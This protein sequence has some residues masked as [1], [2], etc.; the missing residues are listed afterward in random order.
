MKI[1]YI[2]FTD[3]QVRFGSASDKQIL[4]QPHEINIASLQDEEIAVALKSYFNENKNSYQ[5]LVLVLSRSLVH[6]K[7]LALPANDEFEVRQMVGYELATLL[8]YQPEELVFDFAFTQKDES[9]Y[10]RI[11]L[12]AAERSMVSRYLNILKEAG[13]HPAVV[14]VSTI[15]LSNLWRMKESTSGNCMLV[16]VDGATVELDYFKDGILQFSR[17]VTI[18]PVDA[19]A[20][21]VRCVELTT[22]VLRDKGYA[23]DAIVLAGK[24]VPL[25]ELSLAIEKAL[26]YS[27]RV[28]ETLGIEEDFLKDKGPLD[29]KINLLP[30]EVIIQKKSLWRKKTILQCLALL[31]L[32]AALIANLIFFQIKAKAQYLLLLQAEIKKVTPQASILQKKMLKLMMLQEHLKSS[33]GSLALLSELYRIAP[34]GLFLTSLDI[35]YKKPQEVMLV[36]G[37]AKDADNVLQLANALKASRYFRKTDVSYITKKRATVQEQ[38]VDFEIKCFF[39]GQ[40]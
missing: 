9:G 23:I 32:N 37:Q 12:C 17:G 18:K 27:I 40:E 38:I 28:E 10:A 26:P 5:N 29:I 21:I 30:Q 19:I 13:L 7:F 15:A 39:Y 31:L 25:Q 6:L 20:A 8:P 24:G 14:T 16:Y 4:I 36:A 33:R 11:V 34:D 35:S 3:T 2:Y 22:L 1:S